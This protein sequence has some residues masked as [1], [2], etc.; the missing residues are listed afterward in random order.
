MVYSLQGEEN[1]PDLVKAASSTFYTFPFSYTDSYEPG[2]GFLIEN[3]G[4]LFI[5]V[6]EKQ[7]FP[8]IGLEEQAV[9]DEE[10]EEA[11]SDEELD[12]GMM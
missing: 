4:E 11:E 1:S 2:T 3:G 7:D 12:F 5:L 8:L 10:T 9:I 6:G